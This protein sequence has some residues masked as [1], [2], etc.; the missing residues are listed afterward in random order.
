[1]NA[2]LKNN[3]KSDHTKV[4]VGAP[5]HI[6]K[7]WIEDQFLPGMTWDNHTLHGWHIDHK[8]PIAAWN[9]SDPMHQQMVFGIKIYNPC[10]QNKTYKK[11]ID[12]QKKINKSTYKRF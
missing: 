4:L 8:I 5:M 7:Q 10:G 9:L 1:M 11:D 3:T 6:V 12:T 2:A